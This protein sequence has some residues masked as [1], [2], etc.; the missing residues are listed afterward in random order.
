MIFWP[1]QRPCRHATDGLAVRNAFSHDTACAD[2]RARAD[3]RTGKDHR[4][5]TDPCP[6]TD[7][8]RTRLPWIF[9]GQRPVPHVSVSENRCPHRH[10]RV[11]LYGQLVGQVQKYH[12]SDVHIPTNRKVCV[13]TGSVV[14]D[15]RTVQNAFRADRGP[16]K[17]QNSLAAIRKEQAPINCCNAPPAIAHG[18]PPAV[19]ACHHAHGANPSDSARSRR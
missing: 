6:S 15:E 17:L 13:I 5:R 2:D 9:P 4:V 16:E 12:P 8:S 18:E 19:K 10:G 1:A 14:D 3:V 7:A 11:V